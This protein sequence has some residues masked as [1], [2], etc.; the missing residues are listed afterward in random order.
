MAGAAE[1]MAAAAARGRACAT[2]RLVPNVR[3]AELALA[4]GVDELTVTISASETYNEKN[5]GMSVDESVA[6]AGRI[7]GAGGGRVPVDA[8]ISCA[9][10]SPYEGDIDPGGGGRAR[11]AAP[12]R[13]ARRRSPAPTRP[14]WP[15][16]G[17]STS[18]VRRETGDRASGCTCTTPGAPPWST[19]TP[20]SSGAFARFDTLGRRPR[21][22]AVRRRGGR[23]PGHRGP[24]PPA[25]RPRRR[26]RHRPGARSSASAARWRPWSAIPWPAVLARWDRR[27]PEHAVV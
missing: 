13:R 20:R 9:F 14:A 12:R 11:A 1:V 25:R 21:R 23:Q 18:C 3:G 19:P 24:G 7:A 22:L 6:E 17:G 10:G 2:G 5:V 27:R 4:A 26:H 15:R 8:V 16:P